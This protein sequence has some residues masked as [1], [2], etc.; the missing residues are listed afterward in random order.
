MVLCFSLVQVAIVW[1]E[2]HAISAIFTEIEIE[3]CASR[4]D[5]LRGIH[6][7]KSDNDFDGPGRCKI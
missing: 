5:E 7:P 2:A 6:F 4:N 1:V 3:K